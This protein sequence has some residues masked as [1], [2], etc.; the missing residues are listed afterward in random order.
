[1]TASH[2]ADAMPSRGFG[3]DD[4]ERLYAEAQRAHREWDAW[5]QRNGATNPASVML[6]SSTRP[7]SL[8]G[9]HGRERSRL[10]TRLGT[11]SMLGTPGMGA[12]SPSNARRVP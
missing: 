3:P 6:A 11:T 5:D 2:Y 9:A 7:Q 10:A 12:P 8:R 1:M 4:A